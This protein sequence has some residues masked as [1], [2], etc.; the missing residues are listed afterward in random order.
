VKKGRFARKAREESVKKLDFV[1]RNDHSLN[2]L[3]LRLSPKPRFPLP[4][5]R[6]KDTGVLSISLLNMRT[7]G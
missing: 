4:Q 5:R 2:K 6:D 7:Q 3:A 1:F